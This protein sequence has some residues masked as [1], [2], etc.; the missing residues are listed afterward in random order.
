MAKKQKVI[1]LGGSVAVTDGAVT[2]EEQT[3]DYVVLASVAGSGAYEF[4]DGTSV[5]DPVGAD[6]L[7]DGTATADPIGAVAYD[8]GTASS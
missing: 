4:D 1:M 5:L 2:I 8:D 3:D 6:E 7:D